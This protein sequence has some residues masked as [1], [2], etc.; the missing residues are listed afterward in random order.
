MFW[1]QPKSRSNLWIPVQYN[2]SSCLYNFD[3][4]NGVWLG[5]GEEEKTKQ[6]LSK[7][8]VFI[9]I[10]VEKYDYIY[11][12]CI[13][14]KSK[15]YWRDYQ[16]CSVCFLFHHEQTD[17]LET[18]IRESDPGASSRTGQSAT[19][20]RRLGTVCRLALLYWYIVRF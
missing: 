6:Y 10:T 2:V 14:G 18:C 20:W 11:Y 1:S 9:V 12:T 15:I 17:L 8:R 4:L 3:I 5:S 16:E 19:Y 7:S 13:R